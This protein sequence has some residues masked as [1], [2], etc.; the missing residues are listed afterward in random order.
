MDPCRNRNG[1]QDG[2][3]WALLG[4]K[5]VQSRS[6]KGFKMGPNGPIYDLRLI[7][8]ET[9]LVSSG[10]RLDTPLIHVLSKLKPGWFQ[11]GSKGTYP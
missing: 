5:M 8:V 1:L 7:Q 4:P 11:D 10:V 6:R 2:S 9:G 3:T